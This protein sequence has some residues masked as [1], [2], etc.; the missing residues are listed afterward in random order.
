[1]GSRME[2]ALDWWLSGRLLA[3][4]LIEHAGAGV[5]MDCDSAAWRDPTDVNMFRLVRSGAEGGE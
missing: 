3:A 2:L 5:C 1:M 4:N